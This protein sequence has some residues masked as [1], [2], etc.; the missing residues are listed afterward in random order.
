MGSQRYDK[1][2]ETTDCGCDKSRLANSAREITR[3]VAD[4]SGAAQVLLKYCILAVS[5]CHNDANYSCQD[6]H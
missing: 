1:Q 2:R 5:H 4:L 3:M 6:G